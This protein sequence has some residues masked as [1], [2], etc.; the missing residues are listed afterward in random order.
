MY[1]NVSKWLL[2][3]PWLPRCPWLPN[4]IS[5][6]KTARI[7]VPPTIGPHFSPLPS[8]LH[9][10][11]PA[12]GIDT[13]CGDRGE[14]PVFGSL[15]PCTTSTCRSLG[16]WTVF[17]QFQLAHASTQVGR[18]MVPMTVY[19]TLGLVC[20]L[21]TSVWSRS[22]FWNCQPP[23]VPS[24]VIILLR[25][26]LHDSKRECIIDH[27]LYF[28]WPLRLSLCGSPLRCSQGCWST[29]RPNES[30][31][32]CHGWGGPVPLDPS[33][34]QLAVQGL[35]PDVPSMELRLLN[36]WRPP[37]RLLHFFLFWDSPGSWQ[38]ARIWLPTAQHQNHAYV[39]CPVSCG[40]N[41]IQFPGWSLLR[42][43]LGHCLHAIHLSSTWRPSFHLWL[44]SLLP[45]AVQLPEVWIILSCMIVLTTDSSPRANQFMR[46][47][48]QPC[49][50]SLLT[51]LHIV[52]LEEGFCVGPLF[53][54]CVHLPV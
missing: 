22:V 21:C 46:L 25:S 32:Q 8:W 36:C 34:V 41:Y 9:F 4:S 47:V 35:V 10:R 44:I 20:L 7:P 23:T 33:V 3:P 19:F 28:C 27:M 29:Q 18:I 24:L 49:W 50:F 14:A 5:K 30:P 1:C 37:P 2:Y 38:Q 40:R 42:L 15:L 52:A 26:I 12:A 39:Q 16:V 45:S 54:Y 51:T 13:G 31:L 11:V 53:Y 48:V 17:G 6:L 43:P